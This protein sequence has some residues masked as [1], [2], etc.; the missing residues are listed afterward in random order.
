M[1]VLRSVGCRFALGG[2]ER[3]PVARDN[4]FAAAFPMLRGSILALDAGRNGV[5]S[6]SPAAK[7][8]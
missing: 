1:R 8:G 3:V 2:R 5:A 7:P 4:V 6:L